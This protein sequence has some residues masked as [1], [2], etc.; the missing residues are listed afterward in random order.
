M[1]IYYLEY[2]YLKG[3]I[4]ML[5]KNNFQEAIIIFFPLKRRL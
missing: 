4:S 1:P 2:V 3:E 5:V